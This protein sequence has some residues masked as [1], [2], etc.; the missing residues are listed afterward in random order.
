M[1]F[2]DDLWWV[3]TWSPAASSSKSMLD[4]AAALE[5]KALATTPGADSTE[6]YA[7]ARKQL[8]IGA[9]AV[10]A[11][12]AAPAIYAIT[13][14]K[15]SRRGKRAQED[16]TLGVAL[17]NAS[18]GATALLAVGIASPA[19]AAAGAYVLIQKLED[20]KIISRSL[21][22]AAQG[23]MAVAAAGPAI[24]GIGQVARSAFTKGKG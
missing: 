1:G 21:G 6:A 13:R 12:V 23:L 9:A 24:Q 3:L 18:S 14:S 15:R 20:A 5:E 16:E 4:A 19:I 8:I 7:T 17:E 2:L 10:G 22:N 11:I